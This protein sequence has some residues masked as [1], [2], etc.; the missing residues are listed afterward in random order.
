MYLFYS[1]MKM[2][3]DLVNLSNTILKHYGAE[4]FHDSIPELEEALKG[5]KKIALFLFDGAGELVM[6]R[7]PFACKYFLENKFMSISSLN[8]ATTVACTTSITTG[9]YPVETGFLGW[10]L[11]SDEY[12]ATFEPFRNRLAVTQEQLPPNYMETICPV[13]HLDT[14]LGRVGVKAKIMQHHP[15]MADGPKNLREALKKSHSFFENG[16]EFLYFYWPEPDHSLHSYG[17]KSFRVGV[18]LWKL[19]NFLKKFQ[20][21][22]PDVL[23]LTIADHG[24]VD[25]ENYL[26]IADHPDLAS[27]L[28][29]PVSIEGRT[30]TFFTKEGH[31]NEFKYL[32]QKYY[33]EHFDLIPGRVALEQQY[34]GKGVPN[35]RINEFVGH[36]IG[37]SLDNSIICNSNDYKGH[38]MKNTKKGNHAGRSDMEMTICLSLYGTHE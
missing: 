4:T 26:D 11:Q 23:C 35:P 27:T 15:V 24:L 25:I 30:P 37:I 32:F 10:T 9:K 2:R 34:F 12:N 29:K 6:E 17:T 1:A 16:G 33:G 36:Y 21:E 18:L 8:P 38:P 31:R 7:H 28:A 5:H 20:K 22:N 3:Y 19:K 14:L 13:T